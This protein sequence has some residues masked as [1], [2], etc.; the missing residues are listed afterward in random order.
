[1][2]VDR[3]LV[4][5]EGDAVQ[6]VEE[7]S[8][9]EDPPRLSCHRGQQLE[10]A[11]RQFH[12]PAVDSHS[13]SRNIDLQIRDADDI[14]RLIAAVD[15]AEEGAHPRYQLLRAER[16]HHVVVGAQFQAD[17]AVGLVTAGSHDHDWNIRGAA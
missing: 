14:T 17:D 13:H 16:F 7:L 6:H 10:L 15:A 1:V 3:T 8:P 12:R 2:G 9:R 4:G 5:F 11:G